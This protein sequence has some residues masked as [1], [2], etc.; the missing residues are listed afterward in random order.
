TAARASCARTTAGAGRSAVPPWPAWARFL[1]APPQARQCRRH[2]GCC[3]IAPGPIPTRRPRPARPG[4]SHRPPTPTIV[5]PREGPP[6]PDVAFHEDTVRLI[7]ERA[8]A[9]FVLV[10]AAVAAFAVADLTINRDIQGSLLAIAALQ[11]AAAGAGMVGLEGTPTR[12]RAI[13]VP[14]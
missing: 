6:P 13:A 3:R 12:T 4:P 7:A 9:A 14:L 8:R 11:I 5:P 2:G 10:I 1:P